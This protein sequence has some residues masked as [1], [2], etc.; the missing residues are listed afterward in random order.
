MEAGRVAI[1]PPMRILPLVTLLATLGF[2]SPFKTLVDRSGQWEATWQ[3][4]A[5][6]VVPVGSGIWGVHARG[7]QT[8]PHA[9]DLDAPRLTATLAIPSTSSWSLSIV[10]DSGKILSSRTWGRVPKIDP[11]TGAASAAPATTPPTSFESVTGSVRLVNL[12]L[13]LASLQSDGALRVRTKLHVR[14]TWTGS[15]RAAGGTAWKNIVD[16]PGGIGARTSVGGRRLSSTANPLGG[17]TIAI[18][19]GDTAPFTT[20]ED[21]L[22]RLTGAQ[23]YQ[24]TGRSSGLS[25]SNIELLAGTGD[26]VSASN[27]GTVP[28]PGLTVLPI[29]KVDRNGDGI[30]DAADEIWFWARGTSIWKA[31]TTRPGKWWFSIHP[32]SDTRRYYLRVDADG[33]SSELGVSRVPS[34]PAA[35]STV[36]QP[37]WAG[38]PNRLLDYE[39]NEGTKS[40]DANTGTGWYWLDATSS[41]TLS[42]SQ[43]ASSSTTNLPNLSSDSGVATVVTST[44][45]MSSGSFTNLG[46]QVGSTSGKRLSYGGEFATFS[47][48]G[49]AS[50]GN[51]FSLSGTTGFQV[52]GYSVVYQR[53]VSGLDSAAFPAPALGALSVKVGN[54]QTCWV[55]EHG[56][57]APARCPR[58]RSGTARRIPTRGTRCSTPRPSPDR[59]ACLCGRLPAKATRSSIPRLRAAMTWWWWPPASSWTLP[60]R[61]PPGAPTA[62]RS[63]P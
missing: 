44:S 9:G 21:G 47:V 61:T 19:V 20:M 53:D 30:L 51:A 46:I 18:Q 29:H 8:S 52:V 57:Y 41:S 13:P 63:A 6:S 17:T 55:L 38:T 59:W 4:N 40:T 54:S 1:L 27:P 26:T 42:S 50:G 34:S 14:V 25:W 49:L 37:V 2:G 62:S 43:L 7:F 56:R 31:D 39:Y 10:E 32:Y 48:K 60:S 33:A 12:D 15:V 28:A 23:I 5:W 24:V 45:T 36:W 16:N 22:V 3:G 58:A 35:Y 11:G